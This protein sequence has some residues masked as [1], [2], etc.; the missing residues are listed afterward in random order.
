MTGSRHWVRHWW[1]TLQLPYFL[2]WKKIW[3]GAL[4]R[5]FENLGLHADLRV[6]KS[7]R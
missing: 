2:G 7:P 3:W 6:L 4:L 1:W 5:D